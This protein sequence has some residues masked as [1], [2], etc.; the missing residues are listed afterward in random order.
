M[1]GNI[2]KNWCW[3]IVHNEYEKWKNKRVV[4][5]CLR[6]AEGWQ[7]NLSKIFDSRIQWFLVWGKLL[8][9]WM[10]SSLVLNFTGKRDSLSPNLYWGITL[11]EHA[12]GYIKHF[13][14]IVAQVE[15]WQDAAQI[16]D[17]EKDCRCCVCSEKT[18][19]KIQI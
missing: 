1:G 2:S 3:N 10:L 6:N 4:L 5:G 18:C 19:W 8:S 17:K 13:E 7:G 14:W 16:L 11:L 15:Y 9:E 12:F